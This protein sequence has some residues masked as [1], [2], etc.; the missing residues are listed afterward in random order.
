MTRIVNLVQ[1]IFNG[2]V[3]EIKGELVFVGVMMT[4]DGQVAVVRCSLVTGAR[5]LDGILLIE[6][7]LVDILRVI[8]VIKIVNSGSWPM[9]KVVRALSCCSGISKVIMTIK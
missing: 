7:S 1:H 5:I 8:S 2:I 9:G 6:V 4:G 3:G